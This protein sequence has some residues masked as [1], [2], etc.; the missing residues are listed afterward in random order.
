LRL[1]QHYN[2]GI[3][4]L[5]LADGC[6]SYYEAGWSKNTSSQNL[7]EFVGDRGRISLQMKASRSSNQEEGDL[8][9]VYHSDTKEYEAINIQ[10]EYKNMYGQICTLIDMI[11]NHTPGNPTLEEVFSAFSVAMEADRA[12]REK[13]II[14]ISP[15]AYQS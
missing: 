4:T 7:K 6:V 9:S 14:A 11:E 10:A 3:I 12:I 13:K 5:R 1:I 15:T 2:Y 8:I